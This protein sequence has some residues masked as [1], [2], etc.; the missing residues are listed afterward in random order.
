MS[1]PVTVAGFTWTS[2][3]VGL[4]NVMVGGAI[5]AFFRSRAPVRKVAA[6]REANLLAERAKEMAGMREQIEELRMKLDLASEEIRVVRHDLANANHSLDLF[7]AL[8]E[9]NPERAAEHAKRVKEHREEARRQ[10][11]EEKA[12]LTKVRVS[13]IGGNS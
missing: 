2:A 4:L 1:V 6:D 3:L 12:A 5:V 10:I 11:G 9:A 13:K 8:I 7:I